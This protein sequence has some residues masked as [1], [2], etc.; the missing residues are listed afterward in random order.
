MA[1]ISNMDPLA[2][3]WH[4]MSCERIGKEVMAAQAAAA[5]AA[6]PASTTPPVIDAEL[7]VIDA[8]TNVLAVALPFTPFL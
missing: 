6:M 4:E 8:E 1:D 7:P 3:A 2:Q 5:S